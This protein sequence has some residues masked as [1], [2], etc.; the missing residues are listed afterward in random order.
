MGDDWEVVARLP[1]AVACDD[2]CM[3]NVLAADAEREDVVDPLSRRW[4]V[5][6]VCVWPASASKACSVST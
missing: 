1:L 3:T 4:V 5:K 6:V 2:A